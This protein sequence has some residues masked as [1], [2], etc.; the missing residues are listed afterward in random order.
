[1]KNKREK[2][3]DN[4]LLLHLLIA[5]AAVFAV[6]MAVTGWQIRRQTAQFRLALDTLTAYL[7]TATEEEYGDI[8]GEIH[9]SLILRT[10]SAEDLPYLDLIPNTAQDCPLEQACYTQAGGLYLVALNTGELYD[11]SPGQ[12]GDGGV[13]WTRFGYDEVSRSSIVIRCEPEPGTLE[14]HL[15]RE[16]GEVSVQRMKRLFCEESIRQL[17]GVLT[18][19]SVLEFVLFDASD[20]TLY[21][22]AESAEYQLEHYAVSIL[23][24]TETDLNSYD[25]SITARE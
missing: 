13:F 7:S 9:N 2:R 16:G 15:S 8:A 10:L 5:L 23:R 11:L 25:L 18:G 17:A 19:G 24:D 3:F 4:V 22:I 21:P 12:T 20:L 1:M 14:V 6:A